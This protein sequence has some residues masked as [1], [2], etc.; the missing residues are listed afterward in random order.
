MFGIEFLTLP[1]RIEVS[2]CLCHQ[3]GWYFK[4]DSDSAAHYVHCLPPI[5]HTFGQETQYDTRGV[6]P[7]SPIK[8]PLQSF[9]NDRKHTINTM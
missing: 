7:L 8:M 4:D 6:E 1:P 5:L 3:K 2:F 9:M